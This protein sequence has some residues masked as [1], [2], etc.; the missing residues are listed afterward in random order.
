MSSTAPIFT[1]DGLPANVNLGTTSGENVAACRWKKVSEPSY[2]CQAH[3]QSQGYWLPCD[4]LNVGSILCTK[5]A[6]FKSPCGD[7]WPGTMRDYQGAKLL[8]SAQPFCILLRC[9]FFERRKAMSIVLGQS[10]CD[11]IGPRD[12]STHRNAFRSHWPRSRTSPMRRICIT[13]R[14]FSVSI[15]IR[16]I[17]RRRC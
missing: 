3:W 5:A 8:T 10:S 17:S 15:H 7:A 2:I 1:S 13:N 12:M 14:I 6:R 9:Q 16:S 11:T 4:K